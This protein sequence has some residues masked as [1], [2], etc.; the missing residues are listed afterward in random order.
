MNM[1]Y[2]EI[3]MLRLQTCSGYTTEGMLDMS[4]LLRGMNLM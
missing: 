2:Q 1:A 3:K 4:N